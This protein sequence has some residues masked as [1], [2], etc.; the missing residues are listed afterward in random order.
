M[1]SDRSNALHLGKIADCVEMGVID[2][3]Q[4]ERHASED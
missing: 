2:S 4:I 1:K 3:V